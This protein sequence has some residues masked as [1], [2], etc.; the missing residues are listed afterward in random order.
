MD[1]GTHVTKAVNG[2]AIILGLKQ[3]RGLLQGIPDSIRGRVHATEVSNLG[4]LKV[5]KP[6]SSR[7]LCMKACDR[8]RTDPWEGSTWSTTRQGRGGGPECLQ[9]GVK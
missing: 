5:K 2:R 7:K 3:P 6:I 9:G 4:Q 1:T 8:N